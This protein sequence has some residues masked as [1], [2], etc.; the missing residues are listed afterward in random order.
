MNGHQLDDRYSNSSKAAS[1]VQDCTCV[2]FCPECSVEFTLDVKC[3]D[4]QTRL[5]TSADLKTSDAHVVPVTSRNR[6]ADATEYG[7]T[8]GECYNCSLNDHQY[9]QFSPG[10]TYKTFF[11]SVYSNNY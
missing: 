5:V 8:D 9:F 3:T 7:E 2:D 6:D 11:L 4:D 10:I 1:R